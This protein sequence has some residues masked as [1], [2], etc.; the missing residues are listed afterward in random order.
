MLANASG[1]SAYALQ[2]P[3]KGAQ[4]FEMYITIRNIPGAISRITTLLAEN[5]V[6]L[7]KGQFFMEAEKGY[8]AVFVA[9]SSSA[10][11]DEVSSKIKALEDVLEMKHEN[12]YMEVFRYPLSAGSQRSLVF[13]A[14]AVYSSY[15]TLE[16][17]LGLGPTRVIVYNSGYQLGYEL[18]TFLRKTTG[19][20]SMSESVE[21]LVKA[22]KTSGLGDVSISHL[23]E[24]PFEAEATVKD[25]LVQDN[26]AVPSTPVLC[27]LAK[28]I[29]AGALA[30]ISGTPVMSEEHSCQ[31]T[32][33][34]GHTYWIREAN[35]H[36]HPI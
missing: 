19:V 9:C 6:N 14:N 4:I 34:D 15:T 22:F 25:F 21:L 16:K 36:P 31:L 8:F 28:G 29:V 12:S 5:G 23:K 32:G 3:Q 18:A 17:V 7:L 24:A 11:V 10:L 26:P 33:S 1:S 27:D 2:E 30:F 20:S 35:Q 13:S